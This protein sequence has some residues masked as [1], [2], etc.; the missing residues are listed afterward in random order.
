MGARQYVAALGRFLE[1]DPV[2]G[3]VTNNY[4]YPADPINGF[5]LSGEISADGWEGWLKQTYTITDMF[6]SMTFPRSNA[7]GVAQRALEIRQAGALSASQ[8]KARLA[9]YAKAK[10]AA[11]H[12]KAMESADFFGGASAVLGGAALLTVWVPPVAAALGVLSVISGAASTAFT[13]ADNFNALSCRAG[14]L[15][16]PFPAVSR[17]MPT[18]VKRFMFDATLEAWNV[19]S[20]KF[21]S[22]M[23]DA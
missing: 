14:I 4:D 17:L 1:V 6:G 21:G 11:N 20:A 16:T 12:K 7:A 9:V 8:E 5:D 10:A 13:C 22:Q 3:G 18:P 15:F 2:E 19:I 23:G